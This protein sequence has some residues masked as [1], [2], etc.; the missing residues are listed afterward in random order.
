ML[1]ILI[2][3][4]LDVNIF[5]LTNFN[6]IIIFLAQCYAPYITQYVAIKDKKLTEESDYSFTDHDQSSCEELCTQRLTTTVGFFIFLSK[7]LLQKM[8][9][10]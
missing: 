10:N 2:I 4:V 3:T 1:F 6:L 8:F 7:F 5:F 9:K